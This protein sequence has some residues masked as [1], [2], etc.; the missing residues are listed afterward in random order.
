MSSLEGRKVK[1]GTSWRVVY[2]WKGQRKQVKIGL[3]NS[4]TAGRRKAQIEHI[5]AMGIDPAVE[6]NH[7]PSTHSL[8]ELLDRDTAWCK[9]RRQPRAIELTER[10]VQSFINYADNR[11]SIPLRATTLQRF[12][13]ES[14][15]FN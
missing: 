9:H 3:T 6:I 15:A 12:L 5:L 8:S 14:Q 4:R 11:G 13:T 10:V 2:Y 7:Q 1:Q